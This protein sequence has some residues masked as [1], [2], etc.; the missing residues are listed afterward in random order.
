MKVLKTLLDIIYP[1]KPVCL[2]CGRRYDSS[3]ISGIC[4]RCLSRITFIT[5]PCP[6]CGRQV[7]PSSLFEGDLCP[8]CQNKLPNFDIARS[9]FSYTG[10]GREL[11]LKFKYGHRP[12]LASPLVEILFLY[13]K[14]YFSKF[15]IDYIMAIPMHEDREEIRGY[16]QAALLAENLAEKTGIEYKDILLRTKN[17]IPLFSLTRE[18][19]ELELQDVFKLKDNIYYRNFSGKNILIIDDI[20]TTG[21]TVSKTAELF[22]NKLDADKIFV[23]T[24]AS[25]P[26]EIY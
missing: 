1:E 14:E 22:K 6:L 11:L 19:R 5:E 4:S 23:L 24:A 20:L 15:N 21:T 25:V 8:E 3:E 12:D 26:V 7:I 13:F 2:A 10:Y 16:N 9:G 17:S 18:A